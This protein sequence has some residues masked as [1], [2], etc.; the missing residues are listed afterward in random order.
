NVTLSEGFA[1]SMRQ[2]TIAIFL[3]RQPAAD[4]THHRVR[5]TGQ[6]FKGVGQI[7][8]TLPHHGYIGKAVVRVGA[9]KRN[10]DQVC[11]QRAVIAV[12]AVAIKAPYALLRLRSDVVHPLCWS[13]KEANL[14]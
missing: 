1:R 2:R 12:F 3:A 4:Y 6:E 5:N 10:I 13:S 7:L 11:G 8:Q 14:V 9:Q